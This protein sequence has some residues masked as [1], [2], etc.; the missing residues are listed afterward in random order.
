MTA[1]RIS[2]WSDAHPALAYRQTVY[3]IIGFDRINFVGDVANAVP[4]D[5]YCQ[6][7][8]LSFEADGIRVDGRLT[9][10]VQDERHLSA[11][12]RQLR[13]VRGVVSAKQIN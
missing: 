4:Q 10:H 12:D 9:I 1:E 3:Q 8:G 7:T 2:E 11:I 13:A 6:I 5:E